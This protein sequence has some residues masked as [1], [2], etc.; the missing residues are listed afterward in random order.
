MNKEFE[1]V[2]PIVMLRQHS[3]DGNI[4]NFMG[5]SRR[6]DLQASATCR[7]RPSMPTRAQM[8]ERLA[9]DDESDGGEDDE[10]E[11]YDR[12]ID[13]VDTGSENQQTNLDV[14]LQS[15]ATLNVPIAESLAAIEES[16]RI[17]DQAIL[18]RKI[19]CSMTNWVRFQTGSR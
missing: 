11:D 7:T 15:D 17:S 3:E 18:E 2:V 1:I 12:F 14:E 6:V 19:C 4:R 13:L 8:T 5:V 10:E 9:E 16:R